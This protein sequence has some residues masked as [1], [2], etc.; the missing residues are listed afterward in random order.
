[1]TVTSDPIFWAFALVF[2][3]CLMV[4]GLLAWLGRDR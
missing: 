2:G 3:A 1:V 4:I